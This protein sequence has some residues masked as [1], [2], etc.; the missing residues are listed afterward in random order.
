MNRS[1]AAALFALPWLL[2]GPCGQADARTSAAAAAPAIQRLAFAVPA[3]GRPL[4]A[5]HHA[6]QGLIHV[7]RCLN[8]RCAGPLRPRALPGPGPV[9][10]GLSMAIGANGH[11]L[12]SYQNAATLSLEVAA[13]L[14]ADCSS[15]RSATIDEEG[16][17]GGYTSIAVPA[18]GRAVISYYD[19]ALPGVKLARCADAFCS[20]AAVTQIDWPLA[21][22]HSAV[23]I[24]PDG[25]TTIAFQDE[26]GGFLLARCEAQD[27]SGA[28]SINPVDG[29]AAGAGFEPSLRFGADG[30]PIMVYLA[31]A[32]RRI[33][34]ARCADPACAQ[35][36]VSDIDAMGADEVAVDSPA[37][38]LAASGLPLIAYRRSDFQLRLAECNDPAC[39]LPVLTGVKG[40]QAV[41]PGTA[42]A[43]SRDGLRLVAHVGAGDEVR[44]AR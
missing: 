35:A 41:D 18:D 44:V 11:P 38:A 10:A 30:M 24:A 21:G 22:P 37:L 4:L 31:S 9:G 1:L 20:A 43:T 19:A 5:Y 15:V 39:T 23:G 25:R 27:C 7:A 34:F 6:G 2:G 26:H 17:I 16:M 36:S 12:I 40:A 32:P 3:D 29:S 8:T 33:T 13:C 28:V 14:N 42:L